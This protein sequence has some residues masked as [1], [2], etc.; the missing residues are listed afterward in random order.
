MHSHNSVQRQ[1]WPLSVL[2]QTS[3]VWVRA[4]NV[5]HFWD[6]DGWVHS[7][8]VHV[9][10]YMHVLK[11]IKAASSMGSHRIICLL[12]RQWSCGLR[13]GPKIRPCEAYSNHAWVCTFMFVSSKWLLSVQGMQHKALNNIR[14]FQFETTCWVQLT[15]EQ[16]MFNLMTIWVCH[17]CT[18]CCTLLLPFWMIAMDTCITLYR[19]SGRVYICVASKPTHHYWDIHTLLYPTCSDIRM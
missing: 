9:C 8:A 13:L 17:Y 3:A 18:L 10:S 1:L 16:V 15:R 4:F 5:S 12:C 19:L 11:H 14:C 6:A 7:L 2:S